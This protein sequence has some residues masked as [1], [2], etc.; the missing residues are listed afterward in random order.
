[1]KK[2]ILILF[3][4]VFLSTY[5]FAIEVL[6][7]NKNIPTIPDDVMEN[8]KKSSVS[9]FSTSDRGSGI[10]SGT[11]LKNDYD[12][13]E[14]ITAKHCI[15]VYE[16]V[17]VNNISVIYQFSSAKDDL[18]L[19]VTNKTIPNK[20]PA[21]IASYR[22][23]L[24]DYV[25]HMGYPNFEQ[26]TSFGKVSQISVDHQYFKGKVI[27]GCSGGGAFNNKGEFT[28]VVWGS[29]RFKK[30]LGIFEPLQDVKKF[31]KTIGKKYE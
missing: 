16:E 13:A 9:I 7:P 10:C 12:G 26:Y 11:V 14:I 29:L 23:R 17:Y 30:S 31:L 1:M 21:K 5:S 28:G 19:L 3:M 2:I 6:Q 27:P 24:E 20:Y 18:C 15:D 22:T 25:Y 8:M 4:F